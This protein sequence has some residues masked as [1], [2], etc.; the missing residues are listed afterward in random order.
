MK[1]KFSLIAQERLENIASYIYE[2]S[3]SKQI[4]RNYLKK[5]K[6]F[7]IETLSSFPKAGRPSPELLEDSRKLVYQGYSIIYRVKETEIEILT[8]YRENLL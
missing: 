5:F 6:S 8:L 7:I 1:I 2:Q 3:K 4:T